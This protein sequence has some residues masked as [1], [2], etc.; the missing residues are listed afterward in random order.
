MQQLYSQKNF[1][2]LFVL[3]LLFHIACLLFNINEISIHHKEAFG[4]FYSDEFIYELARLSYEFLGQNDFALRAPF[5]AV[6]ICNVILLYLIGL[7]YFKRTLDSY[8]CVL[9]FMFLPGIVLSSILISKTNFI[10]FIALVCVYWQLRF[11]RNPYFMPLLSVFLDSSFSILYLGMFF[12]ALRTKNTPY[13]FFALLCFGVNMSLFGIDVSGRPQSYFIDTLGGL[14]LLFSPLLLIYYIYAL[15][16]S[17]RRQN[18]FMSYVSLSAFMF[19][20]ILSLRQKVDLETLLPLSVIGLPALVR[21]FLGDIRI[22]LPQFR[23]AYILRFVVIFLLM[24]LQSG[25]LCLNKLLYLVQVKTHFAHSY[26]YGKEIAGELRKIDIE[27]IQA[28]DKRL[29]LQLRFYGIDNV[30]PR[31]LRRAEDGENDDIKLMY[32]GK[33]IARYKITYAP[34][35]PTQKAN[36]DSKN[37]KITTKKRAK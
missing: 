26:Y 21:Q 20:L 25:A 33:I 13:L 28:E 2:F 34:N 15:I 1:F 8:L 18:E 32:L 24:F 31:I 9:I 23:R 10:I 3:T 36:K 6:H 16:V 17:S 7:R 4:F 29:E 37:S 11:S 5:L 30:S 12:Y 35:T 19:V 22:R 14:V 27:S